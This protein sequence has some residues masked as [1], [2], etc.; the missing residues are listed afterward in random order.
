MMGSGLE[1]HTVP[2]IG[3][4]IDPSCEEQGDRASSHR[5]DLCN[6]VGLGDRSLSGVGVAWVNGP[7]CRPR[8]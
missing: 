3:I 5:Y 2:Y 4:G 1:H 7:V 6:L 8:W